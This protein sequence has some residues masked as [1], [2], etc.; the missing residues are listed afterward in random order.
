MWM[1]VQFTC[2]KLPNDI[3]LSFMETEL[4]TWDLIFIKTVSSA[5][6]QSQR[7]PDLGLA[8]KTASKMLRSQLFLLTAQQNFQI[9]AALCAHLEI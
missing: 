6:H 1:L 7:G 4:I 5:Q 9:A 3:A 8:P 2:C